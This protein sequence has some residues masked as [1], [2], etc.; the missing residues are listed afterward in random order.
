MW[1]ENRL[2]WSINC[3]IRRITGSVDL[4]PQDILGR[5][6]NENPSWE[7]EMAATIVGFIL[8]GK[9]LDRKV[10]GQQLRVLGDNCVISF[11]R[12]NRRR[13]RQQS[14]YQDKIL[15]LQWFCED[16]SGKNLNFWQQLR[17]LAT[18]ENYGQQWIILGNNSEILATM[19]KLWSTVDNFKATIENFGQQLRSGDGGGGHCIRPR[20]RG[21]GGM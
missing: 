21:L 7:E 13:R 16:F 9:V 5:A 20:F 12:E 2:D 3:W 18:M 6:R 4:E 17:I 8:G 15:R 1:T 11:Q 19:N 14:L 10:F